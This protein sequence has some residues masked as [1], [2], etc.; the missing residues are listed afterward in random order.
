MRHISPD[1]QS[2][3]LLKSYLAAYRT[4]HDAGPTAELAHRVAIHV[5]DLVA[6]AA[7]TNSDATG[8]ASGRELHAARL[9]AIKHWTLARLTSPSLNIAAAAAAAG[10]S[11]RSVQLLF[12]AD[13]A[14]FTGFVLRERL[15][16][17]HRRLSMPR[18]QKGTITEIAY[19]CGFGDLSYF[20]NSFRK[21]Y[22]ET[23]SEVRHGAFAASGA[24]SRPVDRMVIP[25]STDSRRLR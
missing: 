12:K 11:T 3:R 6:L 5:A 13:G 23:P 25:P 4:L 15:T 8:T 14:T 21:T 1:N 2:T 24:P 18:L 19:D 20:T 16:L 22:G 17:A 10:L 9:D 7:G